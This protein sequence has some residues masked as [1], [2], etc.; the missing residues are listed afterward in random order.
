[1]S[2]VA[3]P[4][5]DTFLRGLAEQ[6]TSS[7]LPYGSA[8]K[9]HMVR[10]TH[11]RM[12]ALSSCVQGVCAL[13]PCSDPCLLALPSSARAGELRL[14]DMLSDA[15]D[16]LCELAAHRQPLVRACWASVK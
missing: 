12:E 4:G 1:M 2:C 13:S 8:V 7:I 10:C 16:V 9:L 6:I 3:A 14:Y 5:R 15:G 11:A